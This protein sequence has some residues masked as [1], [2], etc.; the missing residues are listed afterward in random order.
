MLIPVLPRRCG[1]M[2]GYF[3]QAKRRH[4]H[5]RSPR[6][7]NSQDTTGGHFRGQPV[8]PASDLRTG[9]RSAAGDR[10][11]D[12]RHPRRPVVSDAAWGDRVG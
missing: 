6:R 4:D 10:A 9:W 2:H 7:C 8:P 12:G 5:S 3:E 11:P 1:K